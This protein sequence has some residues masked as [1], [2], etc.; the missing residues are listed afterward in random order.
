M[1]PYPEIFFKAESAELLPSEA[2][3][4]QLVANFMRAIPQYVLQIDGHTTFI[5]DPGQNHALGMQRAGVVKKALVNMYKIDPRRV[6]VR[7]WGDEL[8]YY[9]NQNP[10][11]RLRNRRAN[12]YL[13]LPLRNFPYNEKG[14]NTYGVKAVGDLYITKERESDREWAWPAT[15]PPGAPA[16]PVGQAK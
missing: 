16:A 2:L 11:I 5:G 8:P 9:D 6:L 3:K 10:E 13:M 15:P 14:L 12:L 1:F 4:L 7:S